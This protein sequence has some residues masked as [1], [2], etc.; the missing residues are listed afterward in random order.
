MTALRS[1]CNLT[2]PV[3]EFMYFV[4]SVNDFYCLLPVPTGRWLCDR[5]VIPY[6]TRALLCECVIITI[7]TSVIEADVM[8]S[9]SVIVSSRLSFCKQDNWRTRKRTLAKLGN[10]GQGVTLWKWLTFGGDLDPSVDS[11]LLFD[12]CRAM[13]A[14]STAFA[15]MRC[16][17]VCVSVCLCVT[18]V[19]SVK[20]G[21]HIV[22]LFSPSGRP[23][24]LVFPHHTGRQ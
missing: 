12:F 4:H 20:M 9:F 19:H 13:H 10:H 23:I 22:R 17:S 6:N 2:F 5:S 21:K 3:D 24:I 8:W 7:I 15:V 16:P 18:F 14:S 1:V 11:R